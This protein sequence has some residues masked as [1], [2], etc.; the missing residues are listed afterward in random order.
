MINIDSK[1]ID[2]VTF[3]QLNNLLWGYRNSLNIMFRQLLF[4][5]ILKVVG[6]NIIFVD[7]WLLKIKCSRGTNRAKSQLTSQQKSDIKQEIKQINNK[8]R[9]L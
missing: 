6:K 3:S 9:Y 5:D 2:P 1:L 4:K 8:I 7:N